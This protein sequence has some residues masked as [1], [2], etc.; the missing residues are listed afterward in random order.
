MKRLAAAMFLTLSL[1]APVA[2]FAEDP[3]PGAAPAAATDGA[4]PAANGQ[5]NKDCPEGAFCP[6]NPLGPG[7]TSAPV[8]AGRIIN[9]MLGLMGSISFLMFIWGGF[10]WLMSRGNSEMVEKGKSV[11]VWAAIGI[12]VV[13]SSY[14]LVR[15]VLGAFV[16]L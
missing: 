15:F 13:F 11:M 1:L 2:A 16:K 7:G 6:K 4:T 9:A 5:R 8:I 14:A 3:A 10:N 12:V